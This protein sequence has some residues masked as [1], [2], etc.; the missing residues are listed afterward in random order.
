MFIYN[1]SLNKNKIFKISLIFFALLIVSIVSITS[2]RIFNCSEAI[3]KSNVQ[4]IS[5]SNYTNVLKAVHDNILLIF[6]LL[7]LAFCVR[8]MILKIFLIILG[9]N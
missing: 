2:F 6:K 1:V 4:K 7:L 5:T 8:V 9:W 3:S